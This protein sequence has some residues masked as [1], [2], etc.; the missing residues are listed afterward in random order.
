MLRPHTYPRDSGL[1]LGCVCVYQ[2]AQPRNTTDH[3]YGP[4]IPR[5]QMGRRLS[6]VGSSAQ[7]NILVL[8]A[9]LLKR[10]W[11]RSPS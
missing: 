2:H 4:H 5:D 7:E 3:M 1:G 6:A 9:R 8:A 10:L 11:L